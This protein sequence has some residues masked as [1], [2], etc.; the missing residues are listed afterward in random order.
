MCNRGHHLFADPK[1]AAGPKKWWLKSK[2]C[3]LD[4]AVQA[5]NFIAFAVQQLVA[6]LSKAP[7]AV[8]C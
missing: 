6:K 7:A 4:H 2:F 3:N 1:A 5:R 8:D